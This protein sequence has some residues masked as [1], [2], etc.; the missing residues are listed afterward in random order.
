[1]KLQTPFVQLPLRFDAARLAAEISAFA[2]EDWLPH[3]LRYAGNS[4]LPLIAVN[5]DARDDD[6]DGPMRPTRHMERCPYLQQV[7]AS[8]GA[9]WGRTRLMR[10]SGQAEVEPHVDINY[11]WHE[12]V[13]V[14]IPILTQ[15]QVRFICGEGEVNMAAGECW[16]F[17]TWRPHRVINATNETRI[18]LVADTIGSEDFWRIA[19]SGRAAG[20]QH[21][22]GWT[23]HLVAPGDDAAPALMYET[24]NAPVV[25]TPWEARAYISFIFSETAAQPS[26]DATRVA[27][28]QFLGRWHAL[29]ARHGESHDGWPEYRQVLDIF[30]E[31]LDEH[32]RGIHLRN[33]VN[34]HRAMM[35]LV[36]RQA[37]ADKPVALSDQAIESLVTRSSAKASTSHGAGED[38]QFPQP[39]FIVSPPRSGSTLLFE[40]LAQAPHI[41]TIGDESHFLIE[42]IPALHPAA[43]DFESN[44][45]GL[46]DATLEIVDTVRTNFRAALRDRDGRTPVASEAVRTLEK[47]PKNSLRIPFLAKLFPQAQFVYLFRDPREVLASMIEAWN[48]GRFRT[49]PKLPGWQ[50]LPWSLV[51]TPGWRDLGGKPLHEVVAAQWQATT[52][53]LLDDLSALPRERVHVA[54]YDALLAEPATEVARL[55]AML[56]F[57][58]DRP[59]DKTL[60]LSRH[61][62]TQPT[63]DKWRKHAT[64]IERVLPSL[65]HTIARAAQFAAR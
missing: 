59:L 32:A 17:D 11:Y 33:G 40:T 56:G 46:D 4:A 10:L 42:A 26:L 5:G 14:H 65:Q 61:T 57:E 49:Y 47:T 52:R 51:L 15:P 45:L 8:L 34:F 7:L 23:T 55:C 18:H 22:S 60:P 24:V 43:H 41:Y 21:P 19:N 36:V 6:F 29:W 30:T 53:I 9:V 25:M 54:R 38:A 39:V 44:R 48:S 1:M 63:A 35:A 20:M 2:E 37:L 13:R 62:L 64:E 28:Q 3:P 50:G 16:I 58:W 12:R 31:A 27:A